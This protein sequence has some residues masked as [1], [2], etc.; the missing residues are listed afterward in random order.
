MS[1]E[2]V[3]PVTVRFSEE[4]AEFLRNVVGTEPEDIVFEVIERALAER[5]GDTPGIYFDVPETD[6]SSDGPDV[7]KGR[8]GLTDRQIV[9]AI[10][11]TR[12]TPGAAS[13]TPKAAPSVGAHSKG[14]ESDSEG[15]VHKGRPPMKRD[16]S[17]EPWEASDGG[18]VTE[19]GKRSV[20]ELKALG[21]AARKSGASQWPS[22]YEKSLAQDDEPEERPAK[23]QPGAGAPVMRS[24]TRK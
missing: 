8:T 3:V 18:S 23:R 5:F 15:T 11:T 22:W 19:F 10:R 17:G 4:I 20:P 9:K 1:T 12:V 6:S 24:R 14:S 2:I 7:P 13:S 21:I 16:E